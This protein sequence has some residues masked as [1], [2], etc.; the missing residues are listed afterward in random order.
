MKKEPPGGRTTRRRARGSSMPIVRSVERASRIMQ[1]LLAAGP[2][3]KRVSEL[4]VELGLHK[5]TVTRLL[6]TLA[7]AG[8][9]RKDEETGR[10]SW[11]PLT[12]VVLADQLRKP[13]AA[14]T[15]IQHVLRELAEVTE[16]SAVVGRPDPDGRKLRLVAYALPDRPMRVDPR[17][18]GSVPTHG[19]AGGK[20]Y[21]AALETEELEEWLEGPLARQTEHTISSAAEL[22][23]E[24]ARVRKRGYATSREE[25]FGGLASIG[26]AVVDG[27]G[28]PAGA[29][30]LV[31]PVGMLKSG[32]VRRWVPLLRAAA[33][34]IS[35]LVYGMWGGEP[36]GPEEASPSG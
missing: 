23:K 8:G 5:T 25:L 12:W 11:D 35:H 10:Y 20:A 36:E 4:C 7:V 9:V 28:K 24:L 30:D 26:I 32:N 14:Q 16:A 3:G 19:A 15:A 21:L 22:R 1:A 17:E 18:I 33:G 27:K 34:R 6:R 29:L 13:I 31:G 2:G